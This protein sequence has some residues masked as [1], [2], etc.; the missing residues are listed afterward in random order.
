VKARPK[1]LG[2]WR[3]AAGLVLAATDIALLPRYPALGGSFDAVAMAIGVW[4]FRALGRR[5]RQARRSGQDRWGALNLALEVLPGPVRIMILLDLGSWRAVSAVLRGS[6]R[7]LPPGGLSFGY[8]RSERMLCWVFV[9][10][11]VLEVVVTG[12]FMHRTP[13]WLDWDL[14]GVAGI[15]FLFGLGLQFAV[16]PH[17]VS[18]DGLVLRHWALTRLDVPSALI[19]S[20]ASAPLGFGAAETSHPGALVV[21][22]KDGVTVRVDLRE[23]W[24]PKLVPDRAVRLVGTGGVSRIYFSADEP[25]ALAAALRRVLPPDGWVAPEHRSKELASQTSSVVLG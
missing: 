6:R 21:S 2:R 4:R 12:Y 14:A 20:V 1:V 9:P 8:G 5:Y 13:I 25:G 15:W 19:A 18:E 23:E 24:H 16:F 22:T 11:S 10:L 7:S 17:L 3:L